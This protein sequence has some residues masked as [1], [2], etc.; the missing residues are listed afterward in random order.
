M[1]L[2]STK[3]GGYVEDGGQ[4]VVRI[5]QTPGDIVVLSAADTVLSS[6]AEAAAALPADFP[7][8]RLA[9][10]MW[11]RQPASMDWYVDDVLEKAR[12]VIIDH[13]GSP[14]DWA[15]VVERVTELA[16]QRSQWLAL[17]S[18]DTTE[19]PQ[20]LMRSTAPV[21]DCRFLWQCL[22]EGGR[23]NAQAFFALIGHRVWGLGDMPPAPRAMPLTAPHW[24]ERALPHLPVHQP[25]CC[26]FI[27]PTPC[28]AI[29][30][31][32]MP[33]WLR[34]TRVASIHWRWR[35]IRSNHPVVCKRCRRWHG[36]MPWMWY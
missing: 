33:S 17:F 7:S 10:L 12:V 6:L 21:H 29:R 13:L 25:R 4:G 15:Y 11:L 28:R 14:A 27:A 31:C 8:V 35:W 5:E 22:R 26:C 34:C 30:Q 32:S 3:P 19:D 2:L 20:L 18:G 24:P 36:S 16:G 9:N 1:H 23:A